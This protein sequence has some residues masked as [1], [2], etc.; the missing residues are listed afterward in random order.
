MV[1]WVGA[2]GLIVLM[3]CGQEYKYSSTSIVEMLN[4]TICPEYSELSL[5][6]RP[7]E[8]HVRLWRQNFCNGPT[9]LFFFI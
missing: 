2:L 7:D 9:F 3:G 1:S 5:I 6:A 4:F 8:A